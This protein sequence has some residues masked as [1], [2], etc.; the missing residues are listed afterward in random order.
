MEHQRGMLLVKVRVRVMVVV[1]VGGLVR[2]M[3]M[4]MVMIKCI[5]HPRGMPLI[6]RMQEFH[7]SRRGNQNDIL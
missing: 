4:V 5:G 2:V 3:V 6:T 7:A 1:A